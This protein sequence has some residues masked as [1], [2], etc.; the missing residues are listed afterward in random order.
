PAP[1][2]VAVEFSLEPDDTMFGRLLEYLGRLWREQPPPEAPGQRFQVGAAVVNLTGRAETSREM[3]LAGTRIY[4]C[5]SV[6]ER[7]LADE[8]AAATL[9]GIATESI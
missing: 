7:N 8:D 2:A 5:L 3:R 1:W 4:T 6:E 9:E